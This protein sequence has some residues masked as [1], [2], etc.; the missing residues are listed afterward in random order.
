MIAIAPSQRMSLTN[1]FAHHIGLR[2]GLDGILQ[3]HFGEASADS[4]IDPHVASLSIG[5]FT[6]LGGDAKHLSAD[7]LIAQLAGFR[8]II[9]ADRDWHTEILFPTSSGNHLMTS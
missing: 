6:Y 2:T 3:G 1:L 7:Q 5:P 8:V 9:V 4:D